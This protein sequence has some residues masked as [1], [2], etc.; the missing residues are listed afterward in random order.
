MSPAQER[1]DELL[2]VLAKQ[3][4]AIQRVRKLAEQWADSAYMAA[5]YPQSLG[6]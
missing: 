2:Q 3:D 5:G 1:F 6:R 4:T